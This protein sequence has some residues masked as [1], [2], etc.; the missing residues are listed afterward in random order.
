MSVVER[1][2]LFGDN[3]PPTDSTA[4]NRKKGRRT[5]GKAAKKT[6]S[7]EKKYERLEQI[8][9]E[10]ESEDIPLEKL[11]KLFEEGVELV[12]ECSAY[13]QKAR[14]KIESHLEE[15]NGSYTIKGLEAPPGEEPE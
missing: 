2:G 4:K 6:A 11:T 14:L 1:T 5:V 8:L 9:D 13:L 7:F 10:I 3:E 12:K 15:R